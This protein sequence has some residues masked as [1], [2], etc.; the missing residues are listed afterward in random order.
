MTGADR[1]G[2]GALVID[3]GEREGDSC[4]WDVIAASSAR[5]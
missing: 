4:Y 2:E 1:R 3:T 5:K